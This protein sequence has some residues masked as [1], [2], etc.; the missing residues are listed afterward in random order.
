MNINRQL[1]AKMRNAVYQAND[2]ARQRDAEGILT[3]QQWAR[4]LI[5]SQGR[6][7][8]CKEYFGVENLT[9]EHIESLSDGGSN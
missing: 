7:H 5:E 1:A 8:Y 6:C 9:L 3:Y 4:I 2:R